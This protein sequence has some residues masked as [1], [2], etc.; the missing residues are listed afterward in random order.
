MPGSGSGLRVAADADEFFAGEVDLG[1]VGGADAD[2]PAG[3]D[4]FDDEVGLKTNLDATATER[5]SAGYLRDVEEGA[6]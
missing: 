6:L 4:A 2:D 5:D 1:P 3:A